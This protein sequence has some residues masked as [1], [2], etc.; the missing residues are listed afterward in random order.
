MDA[1]KRDYNRQRQTNFR[2][3]LKNRGGRTVTFYLSYDASEALKKHSAD[4]D[5]SQN[6]SLNRILLK[7]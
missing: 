1:S 5:C 3:T 7:L 2:A 6:E 4:N